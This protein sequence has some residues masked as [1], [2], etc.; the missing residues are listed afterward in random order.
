MN[1]HRPLD[2]PLFFTA[3]CCLPLRECINFPVDVTLKRFT[4]LFFGLIFVCTFAC[5]RYTQLVTVHVGHIHCHLMPIGLGHK[6]QKEVSS[7]RRTLRTM[8]RGMA[9]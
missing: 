2:S 8:S 9:S 7:K 4:A 5:V 3:K 6:P 1:C